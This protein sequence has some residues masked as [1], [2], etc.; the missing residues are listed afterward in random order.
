VK[1]LITGA[2]GYLGLEVVKYLRSRDEDFRILVRPGTNSTTLAHLTNDIV[3]GDLTRQIDA[4][5]VLAGVDCVYHLAA[6]TSGSHYEM[7][8]NSVV[9]TENMMRAISMC[10]VKRFVLVSSFS[11]YQMS[12][13][14]YGGLLDE[15]SPVETNLRQR[16]SY[17]IAKIRQEQLV[18]KAC[19]EM[20]IPLVILRPG[21]I[22]GPG[23]S[24]FL[25]QLGLKIPGVCFLYIG[26]RSILPLTHVSN[27][28]E[29]V[30]LAG[31][32]KGC[33]G[34]VFNVVDDDLPNQKEYLKAFESAIGKIPRRIRIPYSTFKLMARML[35]VASNKTKGNVPRVVTRYRAENLWKSL[36]YTNERAKVSLGWQ[37]RVPTQVGLHEMFESWMTPAKS[38]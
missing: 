17:A 4:Q 19:K 33:E 14:K 34:T 7:M 22:Y 20:R 31:L 18:E 27:C 12:A 38:S 16:D 36:R 35:E 8:M 3:Y 23:T 37:P 10:P 32:V 6:G 2:S 26:G 5:K 1:S 24:P 21:K 11:V 30:A 9:A 29:A 13:I 28:A 25:P 15:N